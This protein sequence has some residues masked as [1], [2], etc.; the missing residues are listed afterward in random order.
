MM[1]VEADLTLRP[2]QCMT[3]GGS[4]S[5]RITAPTTGSGVFDRV[6]TAGLERAGS[7]G[8]RLRNA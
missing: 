6:A 3:N 4:G 5:G 8:L 7:H 2:G 1:D